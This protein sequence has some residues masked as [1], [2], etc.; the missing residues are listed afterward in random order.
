MRKDFFFGV[1]TSAYQV[2]GAWNEDGKGESIWDRFCHDARDNKVYRNENAD[3]ACDQYHRYKEDIE[4]MGTI[5]V[6]AHRFSVS[7]SRVIPSGTGKVNQAGLRYYHNFIDEL[8][9]QGIEPFL[10]MY[11]WDLP[12]ALQDRGGWANPDMVNWWLEYATVLFREFGS[13]VKYWISYNEPFVFI[14]GGYGNMGFPPCMR[15]YKTALAAGHIAMKAHF[16]SVKLLHKMVPGAKMGIAL[17]MVPRVPATDKQEDIDIVPLAN[18]TA[19]YWFY[20]VMARGEY[21]ERAVKEYEKRG[22]M[23]EIT[24]YDRALFKNNPCDFIG[25]NYYSTAAI[26]YNPEPVWEGFLH[27]NIVPRTEK[28]G[29][30]ELDPEGL[31]NIIR[32]AAADTEGKIPIIV[33]ENGCGSDCEHLDEKGELHDDYRIKYLQLH[34]QVVKDCIDEGIDVRGYFVWSYLDLFEWALGS[35]WRFGLIYVDYETQKRTPKDSWYWYKQYI[36]DNK[37]E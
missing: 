12:Q 4:H 2:E 10:T 16:E 17:D 18:D 28:L 21:P 32:K 11:H 36:K 8:I 7:W 31:R 22:Y 19:F 25:I 24:D 35:S 5:G 3:V 20:N 13:K 34:S 23:F 14:M 33:T 27:Y 29:G 6:N 37:V 9:K 1:D 26:S 30:N 15:N